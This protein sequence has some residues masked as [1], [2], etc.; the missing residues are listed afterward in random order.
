MAGDPQT[1]CSKPRSARR[2][3]RTAHHRAGPATCADDEV[4]FLRSFVRVHRRF[5]LGCATDSGRG[6]ALEAEQIR[7]WLVALS[8]IVLIAVTIFYAVQT[9]NTVSA[10]REGNRAAQMPHLALQFTWVQRRYAGIAVENVGSGPAKSLNLTLMFYPVPT[11]NELTEE[12]VRLEVPLLRAGRTILV[13]APARNGVPRTL[14]ELCDNYDRVTLTGSI[15]DGEGTEW[16]VN[17]EM[18]NLRHL[19]D[20]YDGP[21]DRPEAPVVQ[22]LQVIEQ[23][24]EGLADQAARIAEAVAPT[25]EAED[26]IEGTAATSDAELDESEYHLPEIPEEDPQ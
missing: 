18:E 24:I 16:P 11:R 8:P 23:R 19:V 21:V 22:S 5:P 6:R 25:G 2:T 15:M 7:E 26:G 12:K 3:R 17:E 1:S 9:R 14:R 10:M 20:L 4:P 13:R